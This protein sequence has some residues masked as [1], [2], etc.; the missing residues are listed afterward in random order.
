MKDLATRELLKNLDARDAEIIDQ[1][2]TLGIA[3]IVTGGTSETRAKELCLLY[4]NALAGS[5][6][7]TY[8]DLDAPRDDYLGGLYAHYDLVITIGTGTTEEEFIAK[9]TKGKTAQ[10]I[11]WR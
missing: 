1:E 7:A 3:I 10:S 5:A 6:A 4:L 8:D 9:G 11:F 2:D